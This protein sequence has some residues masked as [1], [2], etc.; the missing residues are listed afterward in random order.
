MRLYFPPV[1][2]A[3]AYG[4]VV[5]NQLG[6]DKV[7]EYHHFFVINAWGSILT[8]RGAHLTRSCTEPWWSTDYPPSSLGAVLVSHPRLVWDVFSQADPHTYPYPALLWGKWVW[9][10]Q[11]FSKSL[12][13]FFQNMGVEC[14]P[15]R[16]AIDVSAHALRANL[17]VF[18]L[19]FEIVLPWLWLLF[20]WRSQGF[21]GFGRTPLKP[22]QT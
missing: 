3:F 11:L 21:V 6:R 9:R 2:F 1:N 7:C 8:Q 14:W 18:H 13:N 19:L 10:L 22:L 12:L 20:Q 5:F 17:F 15:I 16:S 4:S